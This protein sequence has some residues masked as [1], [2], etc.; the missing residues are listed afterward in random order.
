MKSIKLLF[1][2]CA[3]AFS[4]VSNAQ[5]ILKF[6]ADQMDAYIGE[7]FKIRVTEMNTGYI[8]GGKTINAIA[9]ASFS[10]DLYVL[11]DQRD[12]QID[13]YVDVD[14]SE[15]YDPPPTDHAWRRMIVSASGDALLN[16]AP[17]TNYTDIQF[18][19]DLPFRTYNAVW[20]GKWENLTF[21]STDSIE[22][23]FNLT[24]DSVI[25]NFSTKGVFGNP[26]VVEFSFAE[27]ISGEVDFVNDTIV[28][29]PEAPWSGEVYITNGELH[30]D[31]NNLGFG[32][33]FTGTVGR[34]QVLSLYTVTNGGNPLANGYFYVRELEVLSSTPP[35]EIELIGLTNVTCFG[36]GDGTIS[37]LSTG[38]TPGYWY[39]W[40]NND[41]L[42]EINNLTPGAYDITVT[43]GMGCTASQSYVITEPEAILATVFTQDVSCYGLCDGSA[44]LLIS[45]GSP[46]YNYLWNTGSVS[47]IVDG[48]CEGDYVVTIVDQQ[49]CT[50]ILETTIISPDS[51]TI[52]SIIVVNE[53]GGESNGIIEIIASGGTPPLQ[54]SLDG[55]ISYQ[56]TGIFSNLPAG[57]F[58]GSIMD[59]NGCL[60]ETNAIMVQNI[61]SISDIVEGLRWYP[62]PAQDILIFQ[63]DQDL[64]IS[65]V[66]M[67][68]VVIKQIRSNQTNYLSVK[69][70]VAGIY[71]V[72][73]SDGL[74]AVYEKIVIT[75]K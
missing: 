69:D 51:I 28:F 36:D 47:M 53:T 13:F 3:V 65:I 45:G 21:G 73:F 25:A 4:S 61:T 19:D 55:G 39:Q 38:G 58:S 30:G 22:A 15:A 10:I 37:T 26:E 74:E 35:I 42:P 31:L 40:S 9:D 23:D 33:Q 62:N 57:A 12:Y 2:L 66:D 68:G 67:Q 71:L 59:Q 75:G 11:L 20:G 27:A 8:V 18:E 50:F 70:I 52:D 49:G 48:L 63:T 16:F 64:D 72:R 32:L 14:G 46:P 24:C 29:E 54:Y 41:T 43:D 17:D 5:F 6:Q 34:Q 7:T 60:I 1:I 44:E 56:A